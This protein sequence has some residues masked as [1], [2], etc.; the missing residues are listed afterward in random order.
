MS[1]GTPALTQPDLE[2]AARALRID[3]L[4]AKVV[5]ALAEAGIDSIL[6]KGSTHDFL[7]PGAVRGYVDVDLLVHPGHRHAAG[8]VL[9]AM[10]YRNLLE[11]AAENER[12]PYADTWVRDGAPAVDLH[13]ELP[14]AGAPPDDVWRVLRDEC[15][16]PFVVGSGAARALT[17]DARLL[18]VALHAAKSGPHSTAGLP[19]LVRAASVPLGNWGTAAGIAG[20]VGAIDGFTAGLRMTAQTSEIADRLA[21]TG[22]TPLALALSSSGASSPARSVGRLL[23]TESIRDRVRL[24]LRALVPTRT[25]IRLTS[26]IANRFGAAGLALAYAARPFK[27]AW[28]MPSAVRQVRAT[29]DRRH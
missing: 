19:D 26:P 22:E 27:V 20:R 5:A 1:E 11:G 2:R 15:S 13:F 17:R 24:V 21:L 12:P 3:A 29:L 7:Y 9:R 14:L 18:V 23:T 25:S 16:E 28:R 4:A 10:G 8:G 6:L